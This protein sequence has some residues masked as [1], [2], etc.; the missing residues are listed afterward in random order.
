M[1]FQA[2]FFFSMDDSDLNCSGRGV[3]FRL[4]GNFLPE[5]WGMKGTRQ[6]CSDPSS[7][8]LCRGH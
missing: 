2:F 1:I 4:A 6:V 3:L 7:E 8:S 5:K